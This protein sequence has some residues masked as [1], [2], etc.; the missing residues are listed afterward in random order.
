MGEL[1]RIVHSGIARDASDV[2]R[3]IHVWW[4]N[5]A[6]FWSCVNMSQG[7]LTGRQFQYLFC[8]APLPHKV[9]AAGQQFEKSIPPKSKPLFI[10]RMTRI[11]LAVVATDSTGVCC[12]CWRCGSA[13]VFLRFLRTSEVPLWPDVVESTTDSMAYCSLSSIYCIFM[14][15]CLLVSSW[16]TVVFSQFFVRRDYS[17]SL[18][19][20][21]Q[22][23]TN[24]FVTKSALSDL[25]SPSAWT[26]SKL[27]GSVL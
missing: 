26:C 10:R 23:T 3:H 6:T 7:I 12:P 5:R 17:L 2:F 16:R 25:R 21:W 15:C 19:N 13:D 22:E 14:A 11:T 18:L 24:V 20:P 1:G 27:H 4:I 8:F 9:R